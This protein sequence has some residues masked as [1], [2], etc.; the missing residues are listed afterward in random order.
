MKITYKNTE[1]LERLD[2]RIVLKDVEGIW[3]KSEKVLRL[4]FSGPSEFPG[5]VRSTS[6]DEIFEL[7]LESGE[8]IC[9]K[10]NIVYIEFP[11]NTLADISTSRWSG[12]IEYLESSG[13][14]IGANILRDLGEADVE[15][16]I[17]RDSWYRYYRVSRAA[18]YRNLRRLDED[19]KIISQDYYFYD[20]KKLY[21][22]AA[23][24]PEGGTTIYDFDFY[25]DPTVQLYGYAL[26]DVYRKIGNTETKIGKELVS[27]QDVPGLELY[28]S[29]GTTTNLVSALSTRDLQVRFDHNAL[30]GVGIRNAEFYVSSWSRDGQEIRSNVLRFTEVGEEYDWNITSKVIFTENG[31]PMFLFQYDDFSKGGHRVLRI[32]TSYD[33]ITAADVEISGTGGDFFEEKVYIE[34]LNSGSDIVVDIYPKIDNYDISW[35]PKVSGDTPCSR[36]VSC[37]GHSLTYHAVICPNNGRVYVKNDETENYVSRINLQPE[38]TWGLYS[39][40]SPDLGGSYWRAIAAGEEIIIP[41]PSGTIRSGADNITIVEVESSQSQAPRRLMRSAAMQETIDSDSIDRTR[42]NET[43][44][45]GRGG[46]GTSGGGGGGGSNGGSSGGSSNNKP[47]QTPN[48]PDPP[49]DPEKPDY[50]DLGNL[51]I[52]VGEKKELSIP[53]VSKWQILRGLNNSVIRIDNNTIVVGL[54][55]G[56][57]EIVGGSDKELVIYH[58]FITVS[59]ADSGSSSSGSSGSTAAKGTSDLM[60]STGAEASLWSGK[61][62]GSVIV[63]QVP[64]SLVESEDFPDTILG[65][66]WRNLVPMVFREVPVLKYSIELDL[67]FTMQDFLYDLNLESQYA[68]NTLSAA[69]ISPE[70]YDYIFSGLGTYQP[71]VTAN[72]PVRFKSDSDIISFHKGWL[73]FF[74]ESGGQE[75]IT[76][77]GVYRRMNDGDASAEIAWSEEQYFFIKVDSAVTEPTIINIEYDCLDGR[78]VGGI[79]KHSYSSQEVEGT[80]TIRVAVLPPFPGAFRESSKVILAVKNDM[81]SYNRDIYFR[82]FSE[83]V[84]V[85]VSYFIDENNSPMSIYPNGH[86]DI[87]QVPKWEDNNKPGAKRGYFT[88]NNISGVNPEVPRIKPLGKVSIVPN[89]SSQYM[90]NEWSAV[91]TVYP[92]PES[93]RNA[94]STT[95]TA[96]RT[97][98]QDEIRY[99][100]G[101]FL[102]PPGNLSGA[103]WKGG[104]KFIDISA[105]AGLQVLAYSGEYS[106]SVILDTIFTGSAS[107]YSTFKVGDVLGTVTIRWSGDEVMDI[108]QIIDTNFLYHG[109]GDIPYPYSTQGKIYTQTIKIVKEEV[110]SSIDGDTSVFSA[111]GTFDSYTGAE[112]SKEMYATGAYFP[113]PSDYHHGNYT[114]YEL[115]KIEFE[116]S[117]QY[118]LNPAPGTS[119]FNLVVWPR[120]GVNGVSFN[121]NSDK[122]KTTLQKYQASIYGKFALYRIYKVMYPSSPTDVSTETY[123]TDFE[124]EQEG[125]NEGIVIG[126]TLYSGQMLA[127][128]PLSPKI[129]Y[130]VTS[131]SVSAFS[132]KLSDLSSG[133]RIPVSSLVVEISDSLSGEVVSSNTYPDGKVEKIIIPENTGTEKKVYIV[134]FIHVETPREGVNILHTVSGVIEQDCN[135]WSS[136]VPGVSDYWIYSYGPMNRSLEFNTMIPLRNIKIV[137]VDSEGNEIPDSGLQVGRIRKK[138]EIL[139]EDDSLESVCYTVSLK[140]SPNSMYPEY[141]EDDPDSWKR[142]R[143]IMIKNA[144]IDGSVFEFRQGYYAMLPK[145]SDP[146]PE[147]INDRW[148]LGTRES[149]LTI[150][151]YRNTPRDEYKVLIPFDYTRREIND[152]VEK[153]INVKDL[154]T[155]GILEID[156]SESST[157]LYPAAQYCGEG[158]NL[159]TGSWFRSIETDIITESTDESIEL[160]ALETVYTVSSAGFIERDVIASEIISLKSGILDDNGK[161]L[162]DMGNPVIIN[163]KIQI[164]YRKIGEDLKDE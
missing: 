79:I 142:S 128:V 100:P 82:A 119:R 45:D 98:R 122:T 72:F 104:T 54:E 4:Y 25:N 80:G 110:T 92:L 18:D 29:A 107:L 65:E 6:G 90:T 148:V 34:Y 99:A 76:T 139:G 117:A 161:P 3:D 11:E 15:K 109:A 62:L 40:T 86:I 125:F 141:N 9:S 108:S 33:E 63:V 126:D 102:T 120:Y 95:I 10:G 14:A 51:T 69:G 118:S 46:G 89:Y 123:L 157:T 47:T 147:Y 130:D 70:E 48:N 127:S 103:T 12:N 67:V 2:E 146:E 158:E 136:E 83:D 24:L 21:L 74:G 73:H 28:E 39:V 78:A 114:Y 137:E 149:Q 56:T 143:Y 52:K 153:K 43:P 111:S 134:K 121:L 138:R 26:R 42:D 155:A 27:L 129:R 160:P 144:N 8:E 133:R 7:S 162:Y 91:Y 140:F 23:G 22:L 68:Y 36:T 44:D 50:I 41:T 116:N 156:E 5:L 163:S 58:Y 61:E 124:F 135:A 93:P 64:E 60:I 151:S 53:D 85:D 35:V 71:Y 96:S 159:D 32:N 37:L 145:Y 105:T 19:G 59:P 1:L 20:Y 112:N 77:N 55:V 17:G 75:F 16:F 97:R 106:N 81:R 150:P 30:I 31:E 152:P 131:V 38:N 49:L 66:N 57:S 132:A 88:I 164:W 87:D 84:I 13:Y 94:L 113:S 101:I 115:R 154:I